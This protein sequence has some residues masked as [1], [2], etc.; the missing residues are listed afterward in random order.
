M[1]LSDLHIFR[2][3]VQAGGITRAAERLNRVQSNITTR[4]RQLEAELGVE[5][6]IRAGK[7]LHLTPSGQVLLDYADRLL[8]LAAE[9]REALN[10]QEPRGLL[11]LGSMESTAAVRLPVPMNEY[12]RRYPQVTLELRTDSPQHL[13]SALLNGEVDAVIAAEPLPDAPFEKVPLYDEELVMVAA[14]GH[15]PIKSPK[16]ASPVLAFEAGCPY[17]LRLESWFAHAGEMPE[18]I[19]EITSYHAMLGCAVAGMGV[20]LV[21]R[22]VLATFPDAHL[23]SLHSLPAD[24]GRAMTVLMW[25]KGTLSPK[26][27]AL[28]DVLTAQA[29]LPKTRRKR[30]GNGARAGATQAV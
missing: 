8:D 21:P 5:L 13:A 20:S 4:V 30:R 23:L 24:L 19:V 14:A 1:D 29:V 12:L 6:F 10:D 7:K 16:D 27:R 2:S 28:R 15:A 9:A 26:V 25:R 17:R 18:R 22:M 3:V 11:R